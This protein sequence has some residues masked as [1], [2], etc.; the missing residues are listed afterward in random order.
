MLRC[1]GYFRNLSCPFDA[2]RCR[3]PHCQYRHEAGRRLELPV[4]QPQLLIGSSGLGLGKNIQELEKIKKA[5]QSVKTEVEEEQKELLCYNLVHDNLKNYLTPTNNSIRGNK[6]F[7]DED[8]ACNSPVK[9]KN[10]PISISEKSSRSSKYILDH[11]CPATD[12]EYDPLLNYSVVL[13][14]SWKEEDENDTQHSKNVKMSPCRNFQGSI[15]HSPSENR[16]RSPWKRSRSSSPIKLEIKLQESDD[17]MLIIDAPLVNVSKKRRI[18]KTCKKWNREENEVSFGTNVET[19]RKS[20]TEFLNSLEGKRSEDITVG[21]HN[22]NQSDR[23]KTKFPKIGS[24]YLPVSALNVGSK[25]HTK[26]CPVTKENNISSQI[27]YKMNKE[28]LKKDSVNVIAIKTCNVTEQ[29]NN[30][31]TLQKN[32]TQ[33][34]ICYRGSTKD[35]DTVLQETSKNIPEHLGKWSM[36]VH[37]ENKSFTNTQ[38]SPGLNEKIFLKNCGE[39]CNKTVQTDTKENEIIVL[40]SSEEDDGEEDTEL[41]ASDD[42][43]EE[44]R[45]IFNEFVDREA[46]KEELSK[47]E[48]ALAVQTDV[49]SNVK[50]SVLPRQ[51]RRIAHTAKFDVHTTKEIIAPFKAPLPQQTCNSRILQVQQQ[52]VQITAAVKSGQAFV[53]ATCGSKKTTSVIPATQIQICL[54]VFE[55]QPVGTSSGQMNVQLPGNAL[56][57]VPYKL[58]NNPLKKMAT[59]TNKV[60]SRRRPSVIPELGSKVPHDIRQRYVNF[61]VQ[62]FLKVCATV[63]EAFDK[64]L[65]EEKA[66]YDRCGSKNMYLNIAVNTLKKLR[67]YGSISSHGYPSGNRRTTLTGFKKQEDKNDF[68]GIA[69]YRLLKDYAL[70]EE[71]MKENGFPETNPEKPGSAV[72][73]SATVKAAVSD[74]SSRVCC[75]CG[76]IYTVTS[77][78]RHVRKEECNYHSGKV[79]RHKVPGGL[80]TRYSCCEG[81][82]GSPGCQVAKLHVHDGRKE[83]MDGFVKTFIKPPPL[84]GNHGVFALDCEMCYTTCGL[85]LSRVTVVDPSLHVIYNT[86]VKPDNE[87]IDYNSRLSGV[88]AEDMKSTATSIRDAQAI[89]LNLFSAD[90]ILIGH[91]LESDLLA[92]KMFHNKIVDTSVVFPHRL[93]LPHK[94]ALRNLMADYLQRIIQDDGGG[95]DCSEDAIA[96]MELM[97]WKVKEDTKGRRY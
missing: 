14:S 3:R 92:L 36:Q 13:K 48:P 10:H 51:K 32:K 30:H 50:T 16:C 61:F 60:S 22:V 21:L 29:V 35:G 42:T 77:S 58:S 7:F 19:V 54:N 12:L 88:T 17:D 95:H 67:D 39:N 65:I 82:V 34:S 96:C 43:M 81:V 91:S 31:I 49:E 75:R 71:Q 74:F 44:C 68:T 73:R 45:R 20:E 63:N 57:A 55:V 8:G 56:T 80:E 64:A 87:I 85:E 5:I 2:R 46:Q 9:V 72:L 94:R 69:L 70:T 83:N 47:Q 1:A 4:P 93:G 6:S 11:S 28:I 52:A 53:A 27:K 78:G 24:S 41:S 62:Q 18:S 15:K 38:N 89:L 79:L 86:F 59:I 37:E 84:D 26:H 97:L 23:N 66:I 90:T 33:T 40:D 76:Q 25:V